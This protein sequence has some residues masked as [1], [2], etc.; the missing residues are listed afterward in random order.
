MC[1][2]D[3]LGVDYELVIVFGGIIKMIV[4]CKWLRKYVGIL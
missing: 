2:L 3:S 1:A 4:N